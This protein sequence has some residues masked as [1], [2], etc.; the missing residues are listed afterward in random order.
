MSIHVIALPGGVMPAAVR[1]QHLASALGDEITFH[2][3]DLEVYAG[4]EP[5]P[6]YGIELEVKALARFA[7]SL[8]LDRF[9]LLGYSGGGF[10][11]LAFAGAHPERLLSLALFEPASIPGRLSPEEADLYARLKSE[12]AGLSG[13]EFMSAFI[14]LQVRDGVQVSSPAGPPPPWMG[15]RPLGLAA[16]MEAFG[17]YP[18]DREWLRE[19][20]APTFV[21]YGDLTGEHEGVRAGILGRLLPDIHIRRFKG[22]HHFV[23]PEQIYSADHVQEL[24]LLWN[25]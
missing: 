5:P 1:Y 14:A 21:A 25:R 4:E 20:L 12:L 19:C 22:I 18:F 3:K 23:P 9:H 15:K 10:V 16:M 8:S 7:D 11:S 17:A 2:F 24:R 13:P 6:G